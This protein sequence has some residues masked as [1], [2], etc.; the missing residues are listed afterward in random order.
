MGRTVPS[1]RMIVE[2]EL[3]NLKRFRGFLRSEDKEVFDDLIN[4]C[5]VYAS[6]AGSMASP[7]KEI[8]LII[9]I[10]FAQHKRLMELEKR[11]GMENCP[12]FIHE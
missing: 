12:I 3:H 2:G 4:Q 8:P 9:S 7:V 11:I 5:R 6:Y 10:L 1:W